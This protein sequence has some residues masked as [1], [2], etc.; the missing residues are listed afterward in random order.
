[1]IIDNHVHIFPYLGGNS[2]YKSEGVQLMYAQKLMSIH[3]EPTRK[4]DD[5]S[6]VEV[7]T[8]WDRDKPGPEG[9]RNVDFRAGEFGK[10]EWTV[11][12]VD[13][14]KQYMPV[15]LQDMISP[16]EFI[17]AQM[18]YIG[19]DKGVLQRGHLYG[20][21]EN[22]YH[23]AMRQFPD[24]FIGLTQ[25][26]ESRAYCEDQITELH[27]AIDELKLNGLWFDF[28]GNNCDD[29]IFGPFWKE[30]DSLSIPVYISTGVREF[31]NGMKRCENVLEKHPDIIVVISMGLPEELALKDGKPHIPE[32][33]H[34]LVTKHKVF[35]EICHPI[36][37][38][39]EHEYPYSKAQQMTKH[40]FDTFGPER[41]VW[42]SDM[43]NVERYCTYAQS[44]NYVKNYC[45][46]LSDS[47]KELILSKNLA[48]IFGL[49]F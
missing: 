13:Y 39:K 48:K 42:G 37:M 36:S 17:I 15:G 18:N 38:G 35:I 11:N 12:G 33:V 34:R 40:L 19:I 14:C 6:V 22:Y 45:D 20:K 30:V 47:D 2:E 41:L 29:E 26:D 27:R 9:M 10:Y 46:F 44:L 4:L 5:Y 32:V 28:K 49:A 43:P 16:P 8:L 25:V 31:L 23:E 1:M 21:L 3:Q 7:E 24:R